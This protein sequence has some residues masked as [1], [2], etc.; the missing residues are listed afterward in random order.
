MS[1]KTAMVLA[2]GLGT[3]MRP[4]TDTKPKPL[5]TVGGRPLIDHML[6]RLLEAGVER[7][8]VNTHYCA[9]QLHAHLAGRTRPHIEISH[10]VERPLETGGALKKARSLL[11][12]APIFVANTDSIWMDGAS[13]AQTLAAAWDPAR[14]DALLLVVPLDQAMGFEGA[15][16]FFQADDGRL[17]FRNEAPAAPL[18]YMGLHICK[19]AIVDTE[20]DPAFS[21]AKIW[22]RLA[23]EGRLFGAVFDGFWMH[24]GDP[25]A[26]AAAEAR[27]SRSVAAA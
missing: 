1:P 27:L 12:E 9:D 19:P 4:L 26:L 18:A 2:A 24:V 5:I 20:P 3:R 23:P 21:L 22:R 8:V 7:C 25:E 14:M 17:T 16:D 10:E 13:A 15:G 6:D 11:G